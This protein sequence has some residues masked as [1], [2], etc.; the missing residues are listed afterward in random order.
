MR[1]GFADQVAERGAAAPSVRLRELLALQREAVKV[2]RERLAAA[3]PPELGRELEALVEAWRLSPSN[4]AL[5]RAQRRKVRLALSP[6]AWARVGRQLRPGETPLHLL[7]PARGRALP[8]VTAPVLDVSQTV[9]ARLAAAGPI[10]GRALVVALESAWE[11]LE[12]GRRVPSG[13]AQAIAIELVR[14][15]L[16]GERDVDEELRELEV[17]AAAY[18][19]RRAFGA[20]A[21][22]PSLRAW[23]GRSGAVRLVSLSRVQRAA[24]AVLAASGALEVR[25]AAQVT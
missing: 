23:S 14:R 5:L 7:A 8:Y 20:S 12:P 1:E 2:K 18:V 13:G 17:A 15:R 25:A 24:R 16:A 3:D 6:A 19:C 21:R 11:V 4:L 10:T 22:T 9:G